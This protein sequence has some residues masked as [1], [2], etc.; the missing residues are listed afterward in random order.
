MLPSLPAPKSNVIS[1]IK[2]RVWMTDRRQLRTVW[3]SASQVLIVSR[4]QK[5]FVLCHFRSL[6]GAKSNNIH[7]SALITLGGKK[8]T[9]RTSILLKKSCKSVCIIGLYSPVC[10]PL[11]YLYI[12]FFMIIILSIYLFIYLFFFLLFFPFFSLLLLWVYL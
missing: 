12:L 1:C 10:V 5:L 8:K 6:D 9:S 2:G 4:I 11:P 7:S 3:V